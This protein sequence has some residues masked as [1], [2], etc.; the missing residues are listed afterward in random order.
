MLLN[1]KSH[2]L[3]AHVFI[4]THNRTEGESCG[5][6]GS[7]ALRDE[8]K[9]AAKNKGYKAKVRVNAS[10]CLGICEEGI[11]CVVYPKQIWLTGLKDMDS[12][13]ILAAVEDSLK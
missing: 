1:M 11:A 4:C 6:K 9:L 13:K 7:G 10:G 8:V 12:E 2:H 3:D 5:Q